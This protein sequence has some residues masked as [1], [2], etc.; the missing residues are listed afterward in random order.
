MRNEPVFRNAI[1]EWIAP[2]VLEM[3]DILV[4][5]LVPVVPLYP[6]LRLVKIGKIERREDGGVVRSDVSHPGACKNK[7]DLVG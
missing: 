1:I 4:V 7:G 6:L 5:P 3:L 2:R